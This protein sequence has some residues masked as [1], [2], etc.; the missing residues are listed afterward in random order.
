[1]PQ[2]F[3][4]GTSFYTDS[5]SNR[6]I[7]YFEFTVAHEVVHMWFYSIVGNNQYDAAFIDEGLTN[8]LSGDIYFRHQ[9]GEPVG[10]AAHQTFLYRP[11]QRM[12]EGNAD[13]IVDHP[14]DD[15]PTSNAYV[16]AVYT[17]APMG[18]HAIH[19]AMGDSR[20][21]NGLAA[22]IDE[23]AFRVATPAD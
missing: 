9:Y 3:I 15:F 20:F 5:S 21:F 7:S 17:K 16:S 8:Y 18:F 1:L 6:P 13:V 14:T 12:I 19:M 11:F 4:M 22:Y 23:F 2:M 10:D